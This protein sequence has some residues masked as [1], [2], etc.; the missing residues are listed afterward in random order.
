LDI[1]LDAGDFCVMR[2]DVVSAINSLPERSRF[3]RGLRTWVGYR[4]TGLAYERQARFAGEPKYTFPKLV[5]LGLDGAI[6][7][8]C[9]PLQFI[10]LLAVAMGAL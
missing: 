9:R 5:K 6:N 4:Q 8:S 3:V 1:P 2:R 10:L 7:F